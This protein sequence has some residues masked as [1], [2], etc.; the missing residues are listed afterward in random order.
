MSGCSSYQIEI[1][2][3]H[4][5][6]SFYDL[7]Q[8]DGVAN[9]I[10]D[11][12]THSIDYRKIGEAGEI[13]GKGDCVVTEE[14]VMEYVVSN[15]RHY[16]KP[17]E[18]WI[19]GKLPWVV[20][21]DN[22]NFKRLLG[23]VEESLKEKKIDPSSP[24]Y[25]EAKALAIFWWVLFPAKKN[26]KFM[27]TQ[28][29]QEI[30]QHLSEFKN[31]GLERVIH[32]LE[33]EGGLGYY[34]LRPFDTTL[35]GRIDPSAFSFVTTLSSTINNTLYGYFEEAGIENSV[36]EIIRSRQID[37]SVCDSNV[38]LDHGVGIYL[39][40]DWRV[41]S[42]DE[43]E[44][45]AEQFPFYPIPLSEHLNLLMAGKDLVVQAGAYLMEKK[46]TGLSQE[47][48]EK[49]LN[50]YH[51]H[52]LAVTA[53]LEQQWKEED[54]KGHSDWKSFKEFFVDYP[55]FPS[56]VRQILVLQTVLGQGDF[57]EAR[58]LA[59]QIL[60]K[61]PECLAAKEILGKVLARQSEI[62]AAQKEFEEAE[63]LAFQPEDHSKSFYSQW[64]KL[65]LRQKKGEEAVQA[66]RHHLDREDLNN[67]E[68]QLE[69]LYLAL[70]YIQ[71]GHLNEAQKT[72]KQ[73]I[74]MQFSLDLKTLDEMINVW[75]EDLDHLSVPTLLSQNPFSKSAMAAVYRR[76][77]DGYL[78][79]GSLEKALERYR[80]AKELDPNAEGLDLRLE[81]VR[82]RLS[83]RDTK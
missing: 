26:W 70:A 48:W 19:G 39:G 54:G 17:L 27:A 60:Q 28:Q 33:Q 23:L 68:F 46:G 10:L 64:G 52:P 1:D 37:Q 49:Y 50:H 69:F 9:D 6:R 38:Y 67:N 20:K 53:I 32:Y 75:K 58:R 12:G 5:A 16:R 44:E 47:G 22:P 13:L 42:L 62:K 73:A 72:L 82:I 55:G 51:W 7:L 11:R 66:F 45:H 36:I 31:F 57:L 3:Q 29:K 76:W 63:A 34:Y 4:P 77:G 15:W 2:P 18:K 78:F 83:A 79:H 30:R 56:W 35:K 61:D 25:L 65:L 41:F 24:R 71:A 40:R 74:N 14:E 43:H 81:E 8:K 80:A 21:A 59:E